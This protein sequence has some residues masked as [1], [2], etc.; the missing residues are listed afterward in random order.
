V[1]GFQVPAHPDN[2]FAT[3]KRQRTKA[4]YEEEGQ[5]DDSYM[6]KSYVADAEKEKEEELELDE[7]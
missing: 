2:E 4:T 7:Q 5:S 3:E 1:H 6:D